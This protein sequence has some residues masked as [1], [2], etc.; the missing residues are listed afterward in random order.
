[1]QRDRKG[2]PRKK[3]QEDAEVYCGTG[4][5]FSPKIVIMSSAMCVLGSLWV[6]YTQLSV[7]C[8]VLW[9]PAHIGSYTYW[10]FRVVLLM[11]RGEDVP[12]KETPNPLW[13]SACRADSPSQKASPKPPH[14]IS[15]NARRKTPWL[16]AGNAP[17]E[18]RGLW[19]ANVRA[20]RGPFG[21]CRATHQ[22]TGRCVLRLAR[23]R[24]DIRCF[25]QSGGKTKIWNSLAAQRLIYGPSALVA[26]GFP[27]NP[28]CPSGRPD[29]PP[30]RAG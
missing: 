22:P 19:L 20:R 17:T 6:R 25:V 21:R 15:S 28:S 18:R 12:S 8:P 5:S 14:M 29:H 1:M 2:L 24:W 4:L 9:V 23:F 30:V 27:G 11:L 16:V 7:A 3:R 26:A 13:T 10:R